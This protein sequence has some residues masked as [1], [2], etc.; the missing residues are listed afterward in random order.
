M[1]HLDLLRGAVGDDGKVHVVGS[2]QYGTLRYRVICRFC[3]TPNPAGGTPVMAKFY[4]QRSDV[5]V[6]WL[7]H[8]ASRSHELERERISSS[9]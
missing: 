2:R 1:S 6:E 7:T 8:Q 9:V 5:L 4:G 3:S